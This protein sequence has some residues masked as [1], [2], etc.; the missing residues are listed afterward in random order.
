MFEEA[1]RAFADGVARNSQSTVHTKP[2]ERLT[3][4][5]RE[6]L[7]ACGEVWSR[8]VN[9]HPQV[10]AEGIGWPDLGLTVSNLLCGYIELKAPDSSARPE[11]FS[12]Q[13]Q[14]GKQWER[15]QRLPNLIYTNG[16]EWSLYHAGTRATR[17]R[18]ADDIRDGPGALNHDK[19]R[20]LARLLREFLSWEPV[21]PDTA[22]GLAQ[23]LAPITRFLRD[24]VRDA[25]SCGSQPL[26]R[27]AS[28]WQGVLF[29]KA[30]DDQFADAFAQTLTY[31]LL[32][33]RFEGAVNVRREFAVGK[34]RERKHDLLATA[35][36]LLESARDELSMP[37]DLLER[38]IGV[39]NAPSLL[40]DPQMSLLPLPP[41][42]NDPWLYFYE[43]FS[44]PMTPIFAGTVASTT[45]LSRSCGPRSGLR[46]SCCGTGSSS[47]T[48]SPTAAWSYSILPAAPAPIR[49][50]SSRRRRRW[51]ALATARALSPRSCAISPR[52]ST[53]SRSSSGRIQWRNCGSLSGC[54]RRT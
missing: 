20:E 44:L 28:E 35:L 49:W 19:L 45:P 9:S 53:P 54:T 4:P 39:A 33:A 1:I 51:R 26:R 40:R 3:D 17:V 5:V 31:A 34:L 18:I 25:L 21:A 52:G 42:D 23:F 13:S 29:A 50:L 24:E 16:S 30:D 22:S 14:N 43:N 48:A 47:R 12:K 8:E 11:D 38:A 2:E 27:L 6:L 15:Y 36:D 10:R 37:F 41:V 32:L 7:H 46:N